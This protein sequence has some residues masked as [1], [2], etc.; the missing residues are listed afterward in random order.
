MITEIICINSSHQ[1][2]IF[3]IIFQEGLY[4]TLDT[5][6]CVCI[7]MLNVRGRLSSSLMV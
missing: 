1:T 5:I 6:Y 2:F 3:E 7:F 4:Y